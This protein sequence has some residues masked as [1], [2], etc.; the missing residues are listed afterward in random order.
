MGFTVIAG[1]MAAK[2]T[3]ELIPFC[4]PLSLDKCDI[5]VRI[6]RDCGGGSGES[7]CNAGG[8]TMT[9]DCTVGIEGKTG[10]EMEALVGAT[11]AALCVY[12]MC[13]A[14]SHAIVI[15]ETRLLKKTGGR[16]GDEL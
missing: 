3:A 8:A 2:K 12:D 11:A 15:R 9:I 6:E 16:S 1:T 4:H 14:L 10:V 5:D 13:K 7:S